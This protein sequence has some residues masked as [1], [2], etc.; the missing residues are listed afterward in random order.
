MTNRVTPGDNTLNCLP[1]HGISKR[2]APHIRAVNAME[3]KM[4]TILKTFA[5][6]AV[7]ATPTFAQTPL[8]QERHI[9]DSLIAGQVGDTIRKTCP[10]IS[11][12]MFTVLAALNDLEDYARDKGYTEAEVKAFLKD[13]TEKARIKAAAKAYLAKAGAVEGDAE[14]YCVAGRAEIEKGTLAGSLLRSWK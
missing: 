5:L 14:S 12:K 7:M 3:A 4:T 9:N 13:K 2:S 1:C 10:S 11:A 8:N 6:V